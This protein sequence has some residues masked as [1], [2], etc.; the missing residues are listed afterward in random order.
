MLLFQVTNRNTETST[1]REAEVTQGGTKDLWIYME[2][3]FLQEEATGVKKCVSCCVCFY[4]VH[5]EHLRQG[6]CSSGTH[7]RPW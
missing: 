2:S 1:S 4:E 6:T 5:P 7:G 3:L